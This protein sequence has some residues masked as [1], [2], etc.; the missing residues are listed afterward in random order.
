MGAANA[1]ESCCDKISMAN[2]DRD[3]PDFENPPLTEVLISVQFEPIA[4]MQVPQIGLLWSKY[5]SEFPRTEQH[6]PID[7]AV[8]EFGRPKPPKYQLS[9]SPAPPV[10][11]NLVLERSWL[12]VNSNSIGPV[13]PQLAKGGGPRFV[14]KI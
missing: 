6:S 5:R 3:L 1:L 9:V 10:S 7:T 13:H 11:A 12:R 4:E 14:S 2:S 8:E